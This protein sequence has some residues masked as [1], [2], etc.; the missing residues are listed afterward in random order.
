MIVRMMVV[1]MLAVCVDPVG[2]GPVIGM[3]PAM[4]EPKRTHV[5]TI[6][7]TKRFI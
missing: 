1:V 5:N 3:S 2:A 7:I 4:A 6:A